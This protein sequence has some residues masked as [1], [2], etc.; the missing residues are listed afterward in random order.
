VCVVNVVRS[1]RLAA[2]AYVA[3]VRDERV[4][5]AMAAVPRAAFVPDAEVTAAQRDRPI[6]IACGQVTT[7]PSL[8]AA[9]VEALE[10]EGTERV[11]EVG[12]GLGYEAAVLARL[13]G[14]VWS[15]ERWPQLAE[16]AAENL[17]AQGVENAHVVTGD[18]SRGLP[19][20]APFDAVVVAAAFPRVPPPLAAQLAP[21]GRLVQPIGPGGAEDVILFR[22]RADGGLV[23]MRSL[24]KARFV[25]LCGLHGFAN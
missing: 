21:G 14:E 3:G 6:E 18:G 17:R 8:V 19:D 4:L 15:V 5:E 1:S 24:T 22:R 12:A 7:Q 9:M 20:H 13:A 11:L 16:A 2:A 23:R 10:L 25:R